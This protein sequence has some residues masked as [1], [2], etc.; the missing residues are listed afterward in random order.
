MNQIDSLLDIAFAIYTEFGPNLKIDRKTRLKSVFKELS[1]SE[2]DSLILSLKNIVATVWE[3]AEM[4]GEVKLGKTK[5]K[6]LLIE[7]HPQ[8]NSDGL[9]H[10]IF[11][12]NYY[13]FHEGYD[14]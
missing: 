13:A 2:L 9:K 6:D 12:I 14:K 8:L 4:G 7:K 3:I 1:S 11:L 10:A 5:V